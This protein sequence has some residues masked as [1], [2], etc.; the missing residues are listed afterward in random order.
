MADPYEL[1]EKCYV[2][3]SEKDKEA[4]YSIYEDEIFTLD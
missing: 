3:M 4:L 2:E 1:L